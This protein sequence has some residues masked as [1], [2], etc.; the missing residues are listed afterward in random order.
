MAGPQTRPP[1]GGSSD[2]RRPSPQEAIEYIGSLLEGLRAVAIEAQQP[3]LAYL[4]SVALEEANIRKSD[5]RRATG[6]SHGSV[7]ETS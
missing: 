4:S 6:A 7:S 3:F 5:L 1:G 2:E